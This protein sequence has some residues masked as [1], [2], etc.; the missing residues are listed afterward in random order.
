M[1]GLHSARIVKMF[2]LVGDRGITRKNTNH[3]LPP[4]TR[5]V[6]VVTQTRY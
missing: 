2:G 1:F 6:F 4:S 3:E 5:K